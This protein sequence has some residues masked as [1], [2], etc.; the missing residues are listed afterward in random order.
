MNEKMK[1][2]ERIERAKEII[3]NLEKEKINMT[4]Q[5]EIVLLAMQ[6]LLPG[7]VVQIKSMKVML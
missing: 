4:D 1:T 3:Q 7:Y 6:A 2:A 5:R